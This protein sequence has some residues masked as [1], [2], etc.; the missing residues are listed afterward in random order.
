MA[1]VTV[2]EPKAYLK[3][4]P[5]PAPDKKL[6][7]AN[8]LNPRENPC[9][10]QSTSSAVPTENKSRSVPPVDYKNPAMKRTLLEKKS[11]SILDWFNL[12]SIGR[13]PIWESWGGGKNSNGSQ[14]LFP[15]Q[16]ATGGFLKTFRFGDSSN[17]NGTTA[18]DTEKQSNAHSPSGV[19]EQFQE[20]VDS[21]NEPTKHSFPSWS[22]WK[23]LEEDLR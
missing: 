21:G 16:E 4:N 11:K 6:A 12:S 14:A 7:D 1:N 22:T 17:R 18:S 8:F 10:D 15:T 20:R 13:H 3:Q 9:E 5:S 2:V 19:H 23:R